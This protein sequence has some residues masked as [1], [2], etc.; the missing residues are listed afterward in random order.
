MSA[1]AEALRADSRARLRRMTG[2]ERLAEAL[3]LGR[4]TV[5]AYAAARGIQATEARR[6]LERVAQLGRLPSRVMRL[7]A[8]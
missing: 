3:A 1:V 8:E 5:A 7:L 6:H 2:G 4:R